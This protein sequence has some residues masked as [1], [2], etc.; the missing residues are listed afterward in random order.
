MSLPTPCLSPF[1]FLLPLNKL[2]T[3]S[4]STLTLSQK[5]KQIHEFLSSQSL[6]PDIC[7]SLSSVTANLRK[8]DNALR[9]AYYDLPHIRNLILRLFA[10][11]PGSMFCV[12]APITKSYQPAIPELKPRSPASNTLSHNFASL[13][14]STWS[15]WHGIWFVVTSQRNYSQ[16]ECFNACAYGQHET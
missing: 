12:P 15:G 16:S 2:N 4:L 7:T 3:H 9:S 8:I 6:T 1:L 14:P 10:F 11:P 5:N 13:H